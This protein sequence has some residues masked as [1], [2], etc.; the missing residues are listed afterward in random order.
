M[1]NALLMIAST[2]D[3]SKVKFFSSLVLETVGTHTIV[4]DDFMATG[5]S[6][7]MLVIPSFW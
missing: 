1:F 5:G 7:S 4:S 6:L 3:H 2:D